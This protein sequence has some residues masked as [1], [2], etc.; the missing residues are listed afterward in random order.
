MS[1]AAWFSF[2]V[3]QASFFG[4]ECAVHRFRPRALVLDMDGL[5]VDSEPLW[6]EVER[7]FAR[8]RGGAWTAAHAHGCVGRGLPF[9]VQTMGE[10][11]GF[12][13][14]VERDALALVEGVMARASE[15]TVKPGCRELLA[16]ARGR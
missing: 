2:G 3:L 9:T 5:L 6:F 13:V 4:L 10:T 15:L 11:F 16:A 14:D 8:T 7:E 12:A 1:R